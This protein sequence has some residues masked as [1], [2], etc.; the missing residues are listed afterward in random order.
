MLDLS[1]LR[2]LATVVCAYDG[3]DAPAVHEFHPPVPAHYPPMRI[4]FCFDHCRLAFAALQPTAQLAA[5][6]SGFNRAN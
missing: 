1:H 3:C 5:A 6:W 2:Q 4:M